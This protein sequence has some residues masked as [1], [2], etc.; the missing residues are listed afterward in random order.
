MDAAGRQGPAYRCERGLGPRVPALG[1][2][3]KKSTMAAL[4]CSWRSVHRAES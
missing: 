4:V 1:T 3:A 2:H